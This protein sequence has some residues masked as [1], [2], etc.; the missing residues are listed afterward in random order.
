MKTLLLGAAAAAM[1]LTGF[2]A[3][4][5][6]YGGHAN[7]RGQSQH[8]DWNRGAGRD[9]DQHRSYSYNQRGDWNRG[10]QYRGRGSYSGYG[11]DYGYDRD[12]NGLSSALAGGLLGFVLGGALANNGNSYA[13]P[14]YQQPYSGYG[15]QQ[16]DGYQQPYG[17]R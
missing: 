3:S 6:P 4:A 16:P 13:Q 17:Y 14:A 15:Y 10:V 1:T 7:G 8:S 11:Y 9:S 2:A 12:D 5:Q